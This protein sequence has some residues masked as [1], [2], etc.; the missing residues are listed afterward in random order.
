MNSFKYLTGFVLALLMVT[1]LVWAEDEETQEDEV[2]QVHSS[3]FVCNELK[4]KIDI[5]IPLQ[6]SISR[7]FASLNDGNLCYQT[8][9]QCEHLYRETK[10]YE[11][12]YRKNCDSDY[13]VG[14]SL[15]ACDYS[16]NQCPKFV[17][18]SKPAAKPLSRFHAV[19]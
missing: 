10:D 19:M 14:E 9:K 8:S 6:E 4:E 3:V 12:E 1:P 11:R 7:E 16:A 5:F 17:E 18:K 2:E 13:E 15:T